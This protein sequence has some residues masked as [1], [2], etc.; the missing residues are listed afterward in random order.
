M[1]IGILGGGQLGR[2]TALAGYPLG[3]ACRFLEPARE[4]SA[5]QV[6]ERVLGEFDDYRVLYEFS[7]GLDAVTYEF[8][9]VPVESARWLAE[10]LPVWPPPGA[11]SVAQDR[12]AEK[13]FFATLGIATPQFAA[14]DCRADFDKAIEQ[15][16]LPA[17]LKTTRFGYDGKGQQ[18]LRDPGGSRAGLGT[19]RRPIVD[20][21]G[22]HPV[23]AG[24][25]DHFRA[26]PRRLGRLL[27]AG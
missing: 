25:I 9:N 18:V 3:I 24:V 22:V 4:S 15:I 19:T 7:K 27:P 17:V 1:K 8:E 20:S 12:V 23:P 6:G 2:M 10:R 13:T 14:I 11:L 26:R 21:G 16:G 5:A